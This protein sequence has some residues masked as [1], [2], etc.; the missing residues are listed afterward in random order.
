ML[1]TLRMD[2]SGFLPPSLVSTLRFAV[3]FLLALGSPPP[4]PLLRH[5]SSLFATP[6]HGHSR[7]V[8]LKGRS[9][10]RAARALSQA[11]NGP[12]IQS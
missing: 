8:L 4:F 2:L 10:G 12:K 6:S 11:H 3:A 7:M 1:T 5:F 9:T